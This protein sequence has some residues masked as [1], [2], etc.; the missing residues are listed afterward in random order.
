MQLGVN[1]S[2]DS[3]DS[4]R[5]GS[6]ADGLISRSAPCSDWLIRAEAFRLAR[7][8]LRRIAPSPLTW[9]MYGEAKHSWHDGDC[10]CGGVNHCELSLISSLWAKHMI[11]VLSTAMPFIF[12]SVNLIFGLSSLVQHH[13]QRPS[14]PLCCALLSHRSDTTQHPNGNSNTHRVKGEQPQAAEYNERR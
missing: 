4:E 5:K 12:I 2:Q 1:D 10:E 3:G 9:Q 6:A 13:G 14:L 11:H 8:R 7:V